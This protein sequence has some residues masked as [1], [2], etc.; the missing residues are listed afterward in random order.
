[1]TENST[2][3][4]HEENK[5]P[6]DS[7]PSSKHKPG[8]IV[9]IK[10]GAKNEQE[11]RTEPG[12]YESGYYQR[13]DERF[14]GSLND[15]N[16]KMPTYKKMDDRIKDLREGEPDSDMD[17]TNI[18]DYHRYW[19]QRPEHIKKFGQQSYNV[20]GDDLGFNNPHDPDKKSYKYSEH[21]DEHD[22]TTDEIIEWA[23]NE[24]QHWQGYQL[25]HFVIEN[26]LTDWRKI[27]QI[28]LE[29]QTRH[30]S[31]QT[32]NWDQLKLEGEI[33][34]LKEDIELD[35]NMRPGQ[36]KIHDSEIKRREYDMWYNRRYNK[37]AARELEIF[38]NEL[39][40]LV[41]TKEE[42]YQIDE[43]K[44]E[45][46]IEYWQVR[47]GK[48]AAMDMMAYG[49]VGVGNM[50]AIA[51][52][53]VEDQSR[54]L[55]ITID[56]ASKMSEAM[57]GIEENLKLGTMQG[58]DPKLLTDLQAHIENDE[59]AEAQAKMLAMSDASS[60][61]NP[62]MPVSAKP[63]GVI[64]PAPFKVAPNP[65]VSRHSDIPIVKKNESIRPN[66]TNKK[67]DPMGID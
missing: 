30:K 3:E 49:R 61:E 1:M 18:P 47:M 54:A 50:E 42:L 35:P 48:Q 23:N 11:P 28:K 34:L 60:M 53:P 41:G 22:I 32:A 39:R 27:H 44:E 5:S 13:A 21:D 9:D 7:S 12:G 65:S 20:Q 10:F 67:V 19:D 29:I 45:K 16:P 66:Q 43:N 64:Q 62:S 33:E 63:G 56:Y 51:Q 36:R 38:S 59:L 24:P 8:K 6:G 57:A 58:I 40:N 55:Q 31:L 25:R 52:M 26:Q 37:N 46:E 4:D 17:Y 2:Q 14:G 15:Q